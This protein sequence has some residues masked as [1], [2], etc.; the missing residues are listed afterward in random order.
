MEYLNALLLLG[1]ILIHVKYLSANNQQVIKLHER[2]SGLIREHASWTAHYAE[3]H[4][5]V[6]EYDK[7]VSEYLAIWCCSSQMTK[8]EYLAQKHTPE[9]LQAYL[10]WQEDATIHMKDYIATLDA[11]PPTSDCK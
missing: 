3:L 2:V 5:K 7:K 8:E 4:R 6:D 1:F 9:E 10:K 11:M